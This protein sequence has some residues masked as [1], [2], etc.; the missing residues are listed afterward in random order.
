MRHLGQPV[1]TDFLYREP[2]E[3]L[4][5]QLKQHG[6]YLVPGIISPSRFGIY[7]LAAACMPAKE[8]CARALAA[9]CEAGLRDARL[10]D[11]LLG[12][13][14]ELPAVVASTIL[15]QFQ[16]ACTSAEL[17]AMAEAATYDA[18][19]P[20]LYYTPDSA[21]K[22]QAATDAVRTAAGTWLG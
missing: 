14:S 18:K 7:P 3:V 21:A 2:V 10:Y 17:A 12:N 19:T 22:R 13:Y 15:E 16:V 4:I 5:S 1:A 11:G 9:I 8:Y 20:S 6:S